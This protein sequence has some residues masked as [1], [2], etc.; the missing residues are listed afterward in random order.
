MKTKDLATLKLECWCGGSPVLYGGNEHVRTYIECDCGKRSYQ[1]P[2]WGMDFFINNWIK[3]VGPKKRGEK[4]A[5][6][7]KGDQPKKKGFL[8]KLLGK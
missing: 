1:D 2:M 7:E 6:A 4:N 8:G 3:V 5:H